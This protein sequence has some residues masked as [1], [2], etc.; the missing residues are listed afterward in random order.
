MCIALIPRKCSRKLVL[1][2]TFSLVCLE[3][4]CTHSKNKSRN[5]PSHRQLTRVI[6]GSRREMNIQRWTRLRVVC[7]KS[8]MTGAIIIDEFV[9][10]SPVRRGLKSD[11]NKSVCAVTTTTSI[12]SAKMLIGAVYAQ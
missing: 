6:E 5:F 11:I 2:A 3:K 8:A 1:A 12:E 4:K 10:L 9:S 7:F